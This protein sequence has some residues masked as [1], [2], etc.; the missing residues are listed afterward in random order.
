MTLTEGGDVIEALAAH[1]A[2]K[3]KSHD[4]SLWPLATAFSGLFVPS[5]GR[6][7]L[8]SHNARI[9][10][11]FPAGSSPDFVRSLR[12]SPI[13]ETHTDALI[14]SERKLTFHRAQDQSAPRLNKPQSPAALTAPASLPQ[15][16]P[17]SE[18]AGSDDESL[19]ARSSVYATSV[20]PLRT[21]R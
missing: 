11:G 9:M 15:R 18:P 2:G 3:T 20:P 14:A 10:L 7:D 8:V 1:Q 21:R 12:Q 13:D 4:S 5:S 6:A 19:A 16:A 17:P